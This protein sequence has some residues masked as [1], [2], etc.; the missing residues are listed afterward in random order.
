VKSV[1]YITQLTAEDIRKML[2]AGNVKAGEGITI[3][4]DGNGLTISLDKE[5]LIEY[6]W[7]YVRAHVITDSVGGQC[8]S[9]GTLKQIK[10]AVV[11]DQPFYA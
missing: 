10:N 9:S 11:L 6:I 1:K 8:A 4:N 7:C 2:A 3:E 5:K